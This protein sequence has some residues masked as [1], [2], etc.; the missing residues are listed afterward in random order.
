MQ[1]HHV[2]ET[3]L[4]LVKPSLQITYLNMKRLLFRSI[5]CYMQPNAAALGR[6]TITSNVIRCKSFNWPCNVSSNHHT[7]H[8]GRTER[9]TLARAKCILCLLGKDKQRSDIAIPGHSCISNSK[10]DI[11]S[12]KRWSIC[13]HCVILKIRT[14]NQYQMF[15]IT[16]T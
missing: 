12:S 8:Q 7:G 3:R 14:F 2:K 9:S 4:F 1:Y 6:W 5:L 13:N 15:I 11:N 10:T 16:L